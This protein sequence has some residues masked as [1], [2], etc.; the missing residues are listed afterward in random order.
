MTIHFATP[1][2][3][4]NRRRSWKF[5][6]YLHLDFLQLSI[7]PF[8]LWKLRKSFI[9][10]IEESKQIHDTRLST[11]NRFTHLP[12]ELWQVHDASSTRIKENLEL[13]IH[14]RKATKINCR[15]LLSKTSME[16]LLGQYSDNDELFGIFF[17]L[18][19]FFSGGCFFLLEKNCFQKFPFWLQRLKALIQF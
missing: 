10:S 7:I 19:Y 12:G 17:S 4:R 16:L 18:L 11:I 2:T 14:S 15:D 8:A 3:R 9:F 13:L 5:T 6:V 1:L